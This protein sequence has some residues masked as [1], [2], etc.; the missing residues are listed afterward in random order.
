MDAIEDFLIGYWDYAQWFLAA[1]AVVSLGAW[2][3]LRRPGKAFAILML[4]V[5]FTLA[6]RF[7]AVRDSLGFTPETALAIL[8]TS[9][10][11]V[12]VL[13]YYFVFIRTK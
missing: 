7:L 1:A 8:I 2:I 9:G 13:M 10:L 4:V 12:A 5:Y 11:A 6:A 3:V